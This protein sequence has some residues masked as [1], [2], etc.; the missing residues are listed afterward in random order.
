MNPLMTN[1]AMKDALGPLIQS[2][3]KV[4]DKKAIDYMPDGKV[5]N[6]MFRGIDSLKFEDK[7]TTWGFE[8]P[9]YSNGAIY[10]DL[11]NDGDLDL[12]SN[13]LEDAVG[14]WINKANE[15][16][17][18][19]YLK[20][21]FKGLDKNTFGI[22][23]KVYLKTK[24][25]TQLLQNNAS[26]GFMSSVE[27][28][29]NFGL[30][31]HTKVD[32]LIVV[33]NSGKAQILS[34]TKGNTKVV[35]E[36]KNAT[37]NASDIKLNLITQQFLV[38]DITA[39]DSLIKHV[40]NT[41]YDFSRETLMPFKISTEGPKLG[42][43]DVNNDGLDDIYMPGS[44]FNKGK[45]YIQNSSGRFIFSPQPSIEADS[46]SEDVAAIFFDA[47]NDNDQDLYVVSG[48]N[49]YFDT[50]EEQLDRLYINDGKGRF[51][52][53]PS[54]L[55]Q[56]FSNK[57]CAVPADFDK[58]GD[59][60]LFVGGR[61]VP[62]AYGKNPESY[63]LVNNGK[64]YFTNKTIEIAPELSKFGMITDATWSDFDNDKDLD[65]IVV[66]DWM[67]ITVFE[68]VKNKFEPNTDLFENQNLNGFWQSITST[69]IDNDGDI[70]YVVGNLGT[71]NKFIHDPNPI[72]KMHIG[73]FD[74]NDRF[75]Q[76][77]T[78]NRGKNYFTVNGKDDL[79]K[80]FP[81][82]INKKFVNYKDF[83]GK[84]AKELFGSAFLNKGEEKNVS[85]FESIFIE[86]KG[87]KTFKIH[88]LPAIAQASKIF[89]IY[90]YDIDGDKKPE[91]L[92]TGNFHNVN[93]Y[94]GIY[95]GFNGLILN[96]YL[97]I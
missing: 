74:E 26:R 58:D 90:P 79:G 56:M 2:A 11:D 89:Y 16:K 39:S 42:I 13:E 84:N 34:Q 48:G 95:D 72:L 15:K 19:N 27:P 96:L 94:Q 59:I 62:Y 61:V 33:W 86:N 20:V 81:S 78:Y 25:Q 1:Q 82:L 87:N 24:G 5:H 9:T 6:Y 29:L 53:N 85:K 7:S 41:Y 31:E 65:L 71:N 32:S 23:A 17:I 14:V 43:G 38:E 4:A 63:I 76:I 67:P 46:L 36:E 83:A 52:R 88:S 91:L 30:G 49:E 66:G 55:P 12:V 3:R 8:E 60:D 70:D 97:P 73:D 54:A 18:S 93:P 75:D 57:N 40:E 69:D 47:D 77:M 44:K 80:Q 68:N 35:L 45:L 28:L 51:T 92:I 21:E 10:V 37:L 22:G 50:M 64:G